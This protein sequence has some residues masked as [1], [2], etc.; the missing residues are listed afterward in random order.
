ML[1]PSALPDDAAG[2]VSFPV[3]ATRRAQA[4]WFPGS[5]PSATPVVHVVEEMRDPRPPDRERSHLY[6]PWR[7]ADQPLRE[8]LSQ[9]D[10]PHD[11]GPALSVLAACQAVYLVRSC[12]GLQASRVGLVG[13][14]FGAGIALAAAAFVPDRVAWVVLHQPRPAFYRL[15]DGTITDCP[16]VRSVLDEALAAEGPSALAEPAY[17]DPL[18][19]APKVRVPVFVIAGAADAEAPLAEIDLLHD[20]LA[21][22][23]DSV[24]IDGL[25][26]C[27]SDRLDGFAG[28]LERVDDFAARRS[29]ARLTWP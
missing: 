20:A 8:W 19:F 23:R 25:R 18:G 15:A 29:T 9:A 21:G 26:H 24:I 11:G 10:D 16:A 7:I 12:P 27:P 2:P 6:L 22:P 5:D 13:D 3:T 1:P 14:G 4:V 28:I 17:I